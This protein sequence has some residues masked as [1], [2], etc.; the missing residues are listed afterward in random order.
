MRLARGRRRRRDGGGAECCSPPSPVA[1]KGLTALDW[2]VKKG[3]AEVVTVLRRVERMRGDALAGPAGEAAGGGSGGGGGGGSVKRSASS[4]HVAVYRKLLEQKGCVAARAPCG[5]PPPRSC[6]MCARWGR[7][8][9]AVA[10]T[11]ERILSR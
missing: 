9:V 11:Y 1:Q 2:A 5:R 4:R 3:H 8:V 10:V 7:K 6:V